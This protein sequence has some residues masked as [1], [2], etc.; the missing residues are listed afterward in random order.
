MS[1]NFAQERILKFGTVPKILR[2]KG[3]IYA[4]YCMQQFSCIKRICEAIHIEHIGSFI[5]HYFAFHSLLEEV[6]YIRK[7]RLC[8]RTCMCISVSTVCR[9]SLLLNHFFNFFFIFPSSFI[10]LFF[11]LNTQSYTQRRVL[12]SVAL[13]LLVVPF[14]FIRSLLCVWNRC[15]KRYILSTSLV[16]IVC[17]CYSFFFI[18]SFFSSF[19]SFLLFCTQRYTLFV[20]RSFF[21]S[22]SLFFVQ[23]TQRRLYPL[24]LTYF[25]RELKWLCIW[26]E[27]DLS[28]CCCASVT[29]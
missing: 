7:S 10:C 1:Y 15:A 23:N 18:C 14:Y 26:R 20:V 24:F 2:C 27:G 9:C 19:S 28:L 17:R 22:L 6:C 5:E 11:F 29:L 12:H 8:M 25:W 3:Y 4:V 13:L 16:Y 21:F